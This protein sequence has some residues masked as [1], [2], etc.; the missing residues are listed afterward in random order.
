VK[1][2]QDSV[3]ES[4]IHE[5]RHVFA[6][7]HPALTYLLC[8][9]DDV[10]FA[11]VLHLSFTCDRPCPSIQ[12]SKKSE[13]MRRATKLESDFKKTAGKDVMPVNSSTAQPSPAISDMRGEHLGYSA[14]GAESADG[15]MGDKGMDNQKSRSFTL[16]KS[17]S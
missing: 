9:L 11:L 5:S 3:L 15:L 14:G 10:A 4:N 16:I 7:L 1:S 2:I 17:D 8:I 12:T 6:N 13:K